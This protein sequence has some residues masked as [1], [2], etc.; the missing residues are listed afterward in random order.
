MAAIV[1]VE[2]LGR[3][4]KDRWLWRGV[5]L[6]IHAGERVAVVGRSGTGKTL[7]LRA[8]AALDTVDDGRL[9]WNGAPVRPGAVP[10]YRA[11]VTY[12][13]QRPAVLS[14]T[15][16][17]NLARPFKLAQH[18]G[19]VF[20][21][22]RA[23]ELCTRLGMP[24]AFLEAGTDGLSGGEMQV[25]ALVRALL[26]EPRVLLLDEPTASLDPARVERVESLVDAWMTET[27][28]RAC[29]WVSHVEAQLDRVTERRF[30]IAEAG[31]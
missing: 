21:R 30:A 9:L 20:D 1:A 22:A 14:G 25:V 23:A 19:R 18:R 17:E 8:L 12:M 28:G 26:V 13:S 15:V 31:E 24:D 29:V 7:L 3:R 6:S 10:A 5:D 16:E 27:S 2:Q 11:S 4:V